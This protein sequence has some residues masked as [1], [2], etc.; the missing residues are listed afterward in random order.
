VIPNSP[1]LDF[2]AWLFFWLVLAWALWQGVPEFLRW[3]QR[4]SD[5]RDD[6]DFFSDELRGEPGPG[7]QA[8]GEGDS[9]GASASPPGPATAA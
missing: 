9:R 3:L 2:C 1:A 5:A 4:D 7:T 6:I 8:R